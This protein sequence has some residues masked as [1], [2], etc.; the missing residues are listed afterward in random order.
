MHE[1]LIRAGVFFSVLLLMA[2]WE[3]VSPRRRL[4][5]A[6]RPRWAHNL[7]LMVL[8]TVMI[9][10][11]FPTAAVGLAIEAARHGWGLLN[12]VALP[13][14][15]LAL[16]GIIALDFAIY[17]QH[18]LFHAVPALWRIHRMHHADLD[19][20]VSTGARFHPFEIALS[21]LAK[22]AVIAALGPSAAAVLIFEVLLNATA[23]FNHSNVNLPL[24]LDRVLRR[25]VVTPDMHR[26]HHSVIADEANSN[27]G[28]NLA[29]WDRLLGTYCAE[30]QAG[31]IAMSIGIPGYRDPRQVNRLSG[32][33]AMP[34]SK[35][36]E[37]LRG[38]D[39]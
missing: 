34:F 1:P 31:H 20:D 28:F 16:L 25:L 2:L 24:A 27:F 19:F 17:M 36:P 23:M 21:M 18:V 4:S 7:G 5:I 8:N 15:A 11:L 13:A 3:H 10:A 35:V 22:F 38:M 29:I 37:S 26:V 9:R 33:L 14:G 6:K 39:N 32:M 30:P 12:H